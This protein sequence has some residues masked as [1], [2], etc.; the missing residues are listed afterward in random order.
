MITYILC[1]VIAFQMLVGIL[2]EILHRIERKDLY[3]RIMAKT[4]SEYK[5]EGKHKIR[6]R[7]ES[8]MKEWRGKRGDE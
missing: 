2:Q 4:L 8:I 3:S 1:G 6:S 5:S 7:H